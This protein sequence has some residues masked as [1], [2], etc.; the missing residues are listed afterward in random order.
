MKTN[1]SKDDL[2]YRINTP[3][4]LYDFLLRLDYMLPKLDSP[5]CTTAFMTQVYE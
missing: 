5:L 1:L 4:T 3:A 2:Q